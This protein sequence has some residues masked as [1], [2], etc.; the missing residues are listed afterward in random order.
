MKKMDDKN[1]KIRFR[2]EKLPPDGQFGI[3]VAFGLALSNA[4]FF[5]HFLS[6]GLIYND[7]LVN[8]GGGSKA[9]TLLVGCT[10]ITMSFA[11]LFVGVLLKKFSIQTVG[12]MGG[13]SYTLGSFLT[14][15]ATSIELL[16]VSY[17]IFQGFGIG[18]M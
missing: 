12:L 2:T 7:F 16:C 8:I 1:T 3:A 9:A 4:I 5:G 10:A 11:S 6:F 18:V 17:G 14:I 15:F 13:I